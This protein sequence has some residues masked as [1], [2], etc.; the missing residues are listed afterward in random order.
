MTTSPAIQVWPYD[1]APEEYRRLSTHGG[2]EDW[3]ALV[4][5][6]YVSTWIPWMESGSSF[7]CCDVYE[8]PLPDGSVVRIGA[9]S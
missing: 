5:A 2:D 1:D 7:G 6:Q 4:P 3:V 8:Y 9:H